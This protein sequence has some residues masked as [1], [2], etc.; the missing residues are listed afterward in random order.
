MSLVHRKQTFKML[1]CMAGIGGFLAINSFAQYP[2]G[3]GTPPPGGGGTPPP[4]GGA[5]P[6]GGGP[7]SIYNFH[8]N[9]HLGF[10]R[11]EAWGLKYFASASLLSGLQPPAP[12]E[13]Y[14]LGSITVGFEVG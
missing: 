1:L 2:G 8:S 11:P 7:T 3:G 5:P 6:P 9:Y 4:G 14:H 10:D 12:P 13:G